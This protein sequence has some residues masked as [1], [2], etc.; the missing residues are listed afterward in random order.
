[1][2]QVYLDNKHKKTPEQGQKPKTSFERH[3]YALS[4]SSFL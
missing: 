1:M 4:N 2:S 3:Q